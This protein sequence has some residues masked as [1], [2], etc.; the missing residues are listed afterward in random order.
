MK[1]GSASQCHQ[2]SAWLRMSCMFGC[3][4]DERGRKFC[5]PCSLGHDHGSRQSTP[6]LDPDRY[7]MP[8]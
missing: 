2:C 1:L 7:R 6:R 5:E 8:E 4:I 3:P